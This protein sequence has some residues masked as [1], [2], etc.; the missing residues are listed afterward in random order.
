MAAE[1]SSANQEELAA[2]EVEQQQQ[3]R[4][5]LT[6][7]ERRRNV[8]R[9]R[10]VELMLGSMEQR[11]VSLAYELARELRQT[12]ELRDELRDIFGME[13]LPAV[14]PAFEKV[15]PPETVAKAKAKAKGKS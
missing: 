3:E 12:H 4:A 7:E 11:L 1:G 15:E 8:E 2:G 5:P 9:V 14:A 10:T 13:K 6:A